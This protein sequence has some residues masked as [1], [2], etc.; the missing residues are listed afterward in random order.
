MANTDE[1]TT[2][3]MKVAIKA[4]TPKGFTTNRVGRQRLTMPGFAEA[5]EPVTEGQLYPRGV[6]TQTTSE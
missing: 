2:D 1:R 5:A 3:I 6:N 4:V